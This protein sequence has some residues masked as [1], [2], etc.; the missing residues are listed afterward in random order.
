VITL[1]FYANDYES[2]P[3]WRQIILEL[4]L[5]V[6]CHKNVESTFGVGK[7]L[8]ILPSLPSNLNHGPDC[9]VRKRRAHA[10]VDALV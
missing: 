8:C 4:N 10:C 7:K 9:V 5:S 3:K 2:Q 6:D 1:L